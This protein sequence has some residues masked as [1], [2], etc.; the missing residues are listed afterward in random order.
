MN[1]LQR[2]PSFYLQRGMLVCFPLEPDKRGLWSSIKTLLTR[3]TPSGRY[4]L[5]FPALVLLEDPSL[6]HSGRAWA[7]MQNKGMKQQRISNTSTNYRMWESNENSNKDVPL[8][9]DGE[10]QSMIEFL[11]W[12]LPSLVFQSTLFAMGTPLR[13]W[14]SEVRSLWPLYFTK[15][16]A[17]KYGC[18]YILVAADFS[19]LSLP[20]E[21]QWD[22]WLLSV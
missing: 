1:D 2:N 14:V 10:G 13:A 21:T 16:C 12:I 17:L 8:A 11:C 15:K 3:N 22:V 18:I 9:V 6:S 7:S 5:V 19:S 20:I 4:V